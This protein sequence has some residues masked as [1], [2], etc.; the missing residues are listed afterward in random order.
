MSN[1]LALSFAS[2]PDCAATSVTM[3]S[4]LILSKVAWGTIPFETSWSADT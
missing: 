4:F 1:Q 3:T 2:P